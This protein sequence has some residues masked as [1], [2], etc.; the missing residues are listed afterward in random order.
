M[1]LFLKE[2]DTDATEFM[3]DPECDREELFNTYRQFGVV[4]ALISRWRTIYL[5]HIR[6]H[7][8][9]PGQTYTLL[10]IGFG[11]G[12]IPRRLARWAAEDRIRLRVTG[13][14]TDP[15]AM[16]FVRRQQFPD[17]VRFRRASSTD[18]A[19]KGDTFDFVISNHLLHHLDREEFHGLLDEARRL[20]TRKVL[21]NDIERSDL[22]YLL[23]NLLARPIFRSSF[24]THD[25]L[26]SIR[27]SYTRSEL[28]L[29]IP[30]NWRVERIFP[31][32]LLLIYEHGS[33]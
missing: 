25:G 18:L 12:D 32:R 13:I 1:P 30:D 26:T 2:R 16:E 14:E 5:R 22:G 7:C 33:A 11:G 23:F 17:S 28:E 21:F 20:S 15:R 6:P 29:R 4:N 31:Y 27:R 19:E 24:I 8:A 3:D 10:D 9:D